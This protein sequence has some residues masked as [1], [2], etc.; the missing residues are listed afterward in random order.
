M[1]TELSHLLYMVTI[2][3]K[4][5]EETF[6][7][8]ESWATEVNP[9]WVIGLDGDLGSGKTQL[10]KGIAKGLSITE[11][12]TSPTFT[13]ASEYEGTHKLDHLDFYRLENDCEILTSGL[14]PYFKPEG[15]AVIEWFCR[16][17]GPRPMY[18]RHATITQTDENERQISYE[19]FSP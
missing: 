10:V 2:I 14:E 7:L 4:S 13:L 9:G 18:L 17:T 5:P 16:W 6:A 11:T 1:K 3:S 19:D 8:G 15:V 12:I